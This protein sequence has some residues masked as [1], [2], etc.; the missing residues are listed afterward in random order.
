MKEALEKYIAENWED[1]CRC[2]ENIPFRHTHNLK[3]MPVFKDCCEEC[4]GDL[5]FHSQTIGFSFMEQGVFYPSNTVICVNNPFHSLRIM[6]PA[7][8][9][10]LVHDQVGRKINI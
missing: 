9:Y 1:E 7:I 5:I 8:Y 10:S 4:G 3:E 2:G 6:L